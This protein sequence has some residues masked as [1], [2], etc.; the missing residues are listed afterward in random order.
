MVSLAKAMSE[1]GRAGVPTVEAREA[2]GWLDAGEAVVVDVREPDE[3]AQERIA[4]CVLLPLS[5]F[6]PAELAPFKG[7]KIV[8]HCRG[9][10]RSAEA[11]RLAL[12]V[13]RG[14]PQV[15]SLAG[16]IEAWKACGLATEGGGSARISVM[17]QTQMTIG[18][19]TLAGSVL[20]WLV[21]PL[22]LVLPAFMG[23]GLIVA[24]ATGTCPL[25]TLLGTMPWNRLKTAGGE[26]DSC[27][28]GS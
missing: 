27:G 14:A 22:G 17:R 28:C 19:V 12:S 4:G 20:A 8:V 21:D 26:Q 5:S 6:D 15:Y 24:G 23:A 1:P 7:K 18:A 16:G 3:H 13:E 10:K 11:C 25:A 9:G 2:K